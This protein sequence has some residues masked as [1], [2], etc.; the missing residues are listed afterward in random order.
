MK[1][2]H[3]ASRP[4]AT[5]PNWSLETPISQS[6][7]LSTGEGQLVAL[8]RAVLRRS[9]IVVM[10]E[11]TSSVDMHLDDMVRS[12]LNGT[13]PVN[14]FTSQRY[15]EP[16][17]KSSRKLLSSQLHIVSGQLSIT[18]G[19]WF[20]DPR[21]AFSNLTPRRTCWPIRQEYSQRCVDEVQTGWG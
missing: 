10:D 17:G 21:A 2:C 8:A 14:I 6:G 3:L 19:S 12:Q 15:N 16:Y 4:D 9:Q 18:I 7:P 5:G 1:R 11:A 13:P 20:W